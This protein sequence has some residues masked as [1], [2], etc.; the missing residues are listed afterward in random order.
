MALFFYVENSSSV[1][2]QQL[3]SKKFT[4]KKGYIVEKSYNSIKNEKRF[5]E[6]DET[7]EWKFKHK[8]FMILP[9]NCMELRHLHR[10]NEVKH[11]FVQFT[12][13]AN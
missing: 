11:K 13:S 1:E 7:N 4:F 9:F 2:D 3:L 10:T 5:D 6:T 8:Y 12:K